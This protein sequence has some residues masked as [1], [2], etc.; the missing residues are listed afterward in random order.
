MKKVWFYLDPEYGLQE[1]HHGG[2]HVYEDTGRTLADDWPEAY[3]QAPLW[4]AVMFR[5]ACWIKGCAVELVYR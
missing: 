2:T 1:D 3:F 5:I 4:V